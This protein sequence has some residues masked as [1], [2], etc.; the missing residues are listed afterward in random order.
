M[1]GLPLPAR[2]LRPISRSTRD[3]LKGRKHVVAGTEKSNGVETCYVSP[4]L[5]HSPP[6]SSHTFLLP[7]IVLWFWTSALFGCLPNRIVGFS[8]NVRRV[9]FQ[10]IWVAVSSSINQSFVSGREELTKINLS[11]TEIDVNTT[12][13]YIWGLIKSLLWIAKYPQLWVG[14]VSLG[15]FSGMPTFIT[16][17]VSQPTRN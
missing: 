13:T 5:D 4:P 9:V 16:E 3:I 1:R 11:M 6:W 7:R 8:R 17:C 2:V 15:C 14:V 12:P 10:S